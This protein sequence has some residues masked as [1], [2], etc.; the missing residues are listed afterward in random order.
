MYVPSLPSFFSYLFTL[1]YP[2]KGNNTLDDAICTSTGSSD[3]QTNAWIDSFFFPLTKYLNTH[4]P[5]ANLTT[6]D[7]YNLMSLCAFETLAKVTRSPFCALFGGGALGTGWV[8][9]EYEGDLDKYYETGY[10]QPLGEIQGVGY[11]NELPAR[12]TLFH[13]Q[14]RTQTNTTLDSSPLTFPLDQTFYA[15]FSHDNE[16]IP[17]YASIGLFKQSRDLNVHKADKG[18]NWRAKLLVPFGGGWLLRRWFVSV[19]IL[20]W[21]RVLWNR[22]PVRVEGRKEST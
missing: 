17:I 16:M 6:S 21:V 3:P 13:V 22:V 14:D 10:R 11:T 2:T 20:L 4:A 18:R 9:F 15:D 8:G 7:V 1:P 5:G 12:P 19:R